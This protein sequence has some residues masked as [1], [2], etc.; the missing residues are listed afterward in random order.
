MDNQGKARAALLLRPHTHALALEQR[1]L[2]DGAAAAAVDQQHHDTQ[3]AEAKDST[4]PATAVEARAQASAPAP[5]APRNLVVIDARLENRD[6]L[7]A[8]L[9]VGSTAL[10]V[11]AGQDAIAA[12]SNALAQLG[13]VDSIK[14]DSIQVFSHGATGQFILGN[15]AFTAQTADQLGEQAMAKCA[16]RLSCKAVPGVC[17]WEFIRVYIVV[18]VMAHRRRVLVAMPLPE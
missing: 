8:N 11:D 15:Q 12:I 6:Q 9:P 2:F 16:E 18:L 1:I 4:P 13:K 3:P 5:S 14:V 7:A 10:V 17:T